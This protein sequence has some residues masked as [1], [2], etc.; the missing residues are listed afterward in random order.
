[1]WEWYLTTSHFSM[2]IRVLLLLSLSCC[3]SG[4]AQDESAKS[5]PDSVKA[6]ADSVKSRVDPL[7]AYTTT[8]LQGEPPKIDGY[9]N[10]ADWERVPWGGG[11]FRQN[12]PDAGAP[13]SVQ[14][15]FKI[16]YD[17]KNLYIL[18]RCLDPDPK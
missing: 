3:L 16:I 9:T 12:S 4:N 15:K 17:A 11:D 7:K 1:M 2:R 13:A 5:R 10:D 6:H 14:T 8:F 18:T